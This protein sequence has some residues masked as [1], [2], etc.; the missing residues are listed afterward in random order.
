MVKKIGN[1]LI[2]IILSSFLSVAADTSMRMQ[3]TDTNGKTASRL[4]QGVPF[5]VEVTITTEDKTVGEPAIDDFDQFQMDEPVS[6]RT[7][8]TFFNGVASFKKV[9]R[10]VMRSDQQGTF[11]FGPARLKVGNKEITSNVC[12]IHVAKQQKVNTTSVPAF[13]QIAVDKERVVVGERVLFVMRF[14][15]EQAVQFAG[16]SQPNFAGFSAQELPEPTSGAQTFNGKEFKYVEW[17]MH[18]FPEKAGQLTIPAV[19]G[20]YTITRQR[21]H[22][23]SDFFDRFFS[24]GLKQEKTYSNVLTVAVEE[25]P[26][27]Q[28]AVNGVGSFTQFSAEVDHTTA[29]EG[30]GIVLRLTLKGSGNI[31]QV[32]PPALTV[33]DSLKYYDSKNFIQD[34]KKRTVEKIKHFEYIVQGLQPGTWE[35]P[36]QT[37]VYFDLTERQYK[38]LYTK[39]IHITINQSAVKKQEYIQ[40]DL[41]E[42]LTE[43]TVD[44]ALQLAPLWQESPW[45][46]QNQWHLPWAAF[47]ALFFLPLC[48]VGFVYGRPVYAAYAE[49]KES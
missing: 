40:Q 24:G 3:I 49:K 10:Y 42:V 1:I 19:T 16:I 28:G 34:E 39:P 14:Y 36:A 2:A 13:M 26:A 20:V 22:G 41:S 43:D 48:A 31:A 29:Q 44:P 32:T 17:R 6:V 15:G 46:T 8:N 12:V 35:I 23:N 9:Y 33:P 27:Y 7:V 21:R 38:K 45:I 25:L 47:I 30:E 18:L 37:F 5:M 4:V 11:K